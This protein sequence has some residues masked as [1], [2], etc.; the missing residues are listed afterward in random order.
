MNQCETTRFSCSRRVLLKGFYYQIGSRI[1]TRI[2]VIVKESRNN[3]NEI[4]RYNKQLDAFFYVEV[5]QF[6]TKMYQME[7]VL[8][9]SIL[10][11]PKYQYDICINFECFDL[12]N[13][14][15]LATEKRID[16]DIVFHFEQNKIVSGLSIC[17]FDNKNCFQK[18]IY[19]P[20]AWMVVAGSIGAVVVCL[21]VNYIWKKPSVPQSW[22]NR[23]LLN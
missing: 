21:S 12:K 7:V 4:E 10:L 2:R 3:E 15:H 9:K 22:F 18:V 14:A 11:R 16:H 8:N 20:K 5:S 1:A 6:P 17:R 23:S 13:Y 19:N